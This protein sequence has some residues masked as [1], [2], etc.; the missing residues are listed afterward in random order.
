MKQR[1]Q[2]QGGQGGM[3]EG[4]EN[5]KQNGIAGRREGKVRIHSFLLHRAVLHGGSNPGT[6]LKLPAI[7]HPHF[8]SSSPCT[9]PSWH[10]HPQRLSQNTDL[11]LTLSM[12]R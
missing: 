6:F 5:G 12:L 11:V 2:E 9:E 10:F 8:L 4:E 7:F 3:K 1:Q